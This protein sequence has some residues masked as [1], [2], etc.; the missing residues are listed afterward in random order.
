MANFD[1]RARILE[2]LKEKGWSNADLAYRILCDRRTV[3]YWVQH[4][5]GFNADL[6]LNVCQAFDITPN[7]FFK[8]DDNKPDTPHKPENLTDT[9]ARLQKLST[10]ELQAE[11][12]NIHQQHLLLELA[13]LSKK[14]Q[15]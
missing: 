12:D 4:E 5:R 13:L 7:Q 6:L 15:N 10:A 1:V 9:L 14:E 11:L 2:L 3:A 8:L